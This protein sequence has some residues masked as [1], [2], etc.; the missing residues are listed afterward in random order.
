VVLLGVP[1]GPVLGPLLYMALLFSVFAK[2]RIAAHHNADDLQLYLCVPPAE[3]S[4]AADRLGECLVDVEVWLKAS[5]LISRLNL[6]KTWICP[7]VGQGA[8]S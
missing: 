3:A 7:T 5:R 4:V 1:Q 2:H 6:S 8:A